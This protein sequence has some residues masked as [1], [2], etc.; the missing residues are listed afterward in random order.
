MKLRS[1]PVLLLLLGFATAQ[2]QNARLSGE[3]VDATGGLIRNAEV[4]LTND[5]TQRE[6]VTTTGTAGQFSFPSLMPATYTIQVRAD[7]F[8]TLNR[9]GLALDVQATAK[10]RLALEVGATSE[11]IEI[12]AEAAPVISSSP[13]VESAVTRDQINT[14]PLNSRDFNQLVLLATGAVENINSGN[15]RDFGGVSANGNR[16][17]SNDY[18]IDGAPNNDMYQAG[19]NRRV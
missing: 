10:L 14:L 2:A 4:K 13:S 15:G 12:Q 19:V 11:R 3:I 1:W 16:S 17:F 8:K 5:G 6:F 18:T 7:G 9:P